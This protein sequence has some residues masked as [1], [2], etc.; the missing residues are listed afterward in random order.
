MNQDPWGQILAPLFSCEDLTA[1]VSWWCDLKAATS[2]QRIVATIQGIITVMWKRM[3]LSRYSSPFGSPVFCLLFG[4]FLLCRKSRSLVRAGSKAWVISERDKVKWK[5]VW[6]SCGRH[7]ECWFT[8]SNEQLLKICYSYF[9]WHFSKL[10]D[11]EMNEM[12]KALPSVGE[13]DKEPVDGKDVLRA[14]Q[15]KVRNGECKGHFQIEHKGKATEGWP[16][17]RQ[18]DHVRVNHAPVWRTAS[19]ES[20]VCQALRG[21]QEGQSCP[22]PHMSR[23]R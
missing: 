10:W 14:E 7:G 16:L 9:C 15:N 12:D 19:K 2:P 17:S 11:A 1:S 13:S 22:I 6:H 4:K 3:I 8:K 20:T 23:A 5:W 21:Q 18:P